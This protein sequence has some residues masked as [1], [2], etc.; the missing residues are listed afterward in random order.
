MLAKAGFENKE[1]IYDSGRIIVEE[2]HRA[3]KDEMK[4][5]TKRHLAP[6]GLE[7]VELQHDGWKL[8][9]A[10]ALYVSL[11]EYKAMDGATP[12]PLSVDN[13]GDK[14]S[15]PVESRFKDALERDQPESGEGERMDETLSEAE[16]EM[17]L[18]AT[19]NEEVVPGIFS[20]GNTR[21]LL[22]ALSCDD[23]A[24][25]VT[26]PLGSPGRIYSCHWRASPRTWAWY[27]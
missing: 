22:K 10:G 27:S 6:Y 4:F 19:L 21:E 3:L 16:E 15:L 17:E 1:P 24:D 7:K 2:D 8:D 11:T 12:S 18:G 20:P 26:P 23:W 13:P 5:S 9:A 25:T 14:R